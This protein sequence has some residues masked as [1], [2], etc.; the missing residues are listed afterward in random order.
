M[1]RASTWRLFRKWAPNE[2]EFHESKIEIPG[3]PELLHPQ[4]TRF[5]APGSCQ[6]GDS[7]PSRTGELTIHSS[8]SQAGAGCTP[9]RYVSYQY[10]ALPEACQICPSF[11]RNCLFSCRTLLTNPITCC[12]IYYITLISEP[13]ALTVGIFLLFCGLRSGFLK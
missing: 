4:T 3:P 11:W 7:I 9:C 5:S 1:M 13:N 8:R 12:N 6:A 10:T 2:H